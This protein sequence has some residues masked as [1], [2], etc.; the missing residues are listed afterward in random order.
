MSFIPSAKKALRRAAFATAALLAPSVA[1]ALPAD[2]TYDT[3]ANS[4]YSIV[5]QEFPYAPGENVKVTLTGDDSIVATAGTYSGQDVWDFGRNFTLTL[6]GMSNGSFVETVFPD[7]RVVIFKDFNY[8]SAENNAG[9]GALL[10]F[11]DNGIDSINDS[12][13]SLLDLYDVLSNGGDTVISSVSFDLDIE[14]AGSV[15]GSLSG[16]SATNMSYV[17]EGSTAVP[18]PAALPLMGAGLAAL[19]G[20]AAMRRRQERALKAA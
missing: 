1:S 10:T 16:V 11:Q 2:L 17:T 20:L 5:A 9:Y 12:L 15:G 4:R 18:L 13:P 14:D 6:E 19:G 7:F 3:I 8:A